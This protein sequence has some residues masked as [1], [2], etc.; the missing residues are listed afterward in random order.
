MPSK[1]PPEARSEKQTDRDTLAVAARFLGTVVPRKQTC[2]V[3]YVTVTGGGR[4][5]QV[6][7]LGV[8]GSM[9]KFSLDFS[10]S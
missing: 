9:L 5:L 1:S 4:G 3:A 2:D 10:L 7:E 6:Q 8:L